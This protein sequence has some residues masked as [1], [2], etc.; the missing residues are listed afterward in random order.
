MNNPL[1]ISRLILFLGYFIDI[2]YTEQEETFIEVLQMLVFS[3][4]SSNLAIVHQATDTLKT[5]ISD[6]DIIPRIMPHIP[7]LLG[8]IEQCFETVNIPSFFD[9]TSEVIKCYQTSISVG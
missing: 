1:L 7:D 3:L 9:F 4:K 6:R 8:F 5:I 2:L